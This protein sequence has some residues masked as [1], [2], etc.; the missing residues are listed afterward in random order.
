MLQKK[1]ICMATCSVHLTIFN[2]NGTLSALLPLSTSFLFVDKPLLTCLSFPATVG[3]NAWRELGRVTL[4]ITRTIV[5]EYF[6]LKVWASRRTFITN[7]FKSKTQPVQLP[8]YNSE[9]LKWLLKSISFRIAHEEVGNLRC[10]FWFCWFFFSLRRWIERF[11]SER[12]QIATKSE[13]KCATGD[14]SLWCG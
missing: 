7:T 3:V 13:V 6:I 10:N 5:C 1:R 8:D 2:T 11:W 14:R 9:F 4:Q 12:A